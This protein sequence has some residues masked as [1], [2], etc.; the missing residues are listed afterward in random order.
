MDNITSEYTYANHLKGKIILICRI[1]QLI[2]L[3][4]LN[5]CA[6][7]C[8]DDAD[9]KLP[10]KVSVDSCKFELSV[11]HSCAAQIISKKRTNLVLE[12]VEPGQ[13]YEVRLP[14]VGCQQWFDCARPNVPLCGEVGSDL[15]NLF[16]S[17]KRVKDALWFS[18]IAEVT[19]KTGKTLDYYDL[20]R[21]SQITINQAGL[22]VFYPNDAEGILFADQFITNNHGTVVLV[23]RRLH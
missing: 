8:R 18:V 23:I 9:L 3:C 6:F 13:V 11:G 17:R 21:A 15:M 2:L 10:S 19:S 5:G 22:L 20:C 16:K 4:A 12:S 1:A 14:D 7:N